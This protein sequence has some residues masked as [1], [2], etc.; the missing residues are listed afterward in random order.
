MEKATNWSGGKWVRRPVAS[1][2][3][4]SRESR[5]GRRGDFALTVTAR[6]PPQFPRPTVNFRLRPSRSRPPRFPSHPTA[7]TRT[8]ATA[9]AAAAVTSVAMDLCKPHTSSSTHAAAFS[10]P[11]RLTRVL[12]VYSYPPSGYGSLSPAWGFGYIPKINRTRVCGYG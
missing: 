1:G 6:Q 8:F 3:S 11:V 9:A 10:R 5:I 12:T 4:P 2:S 7:P